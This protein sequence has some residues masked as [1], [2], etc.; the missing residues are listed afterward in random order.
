M[1]SAFVFSKK[2]FYDPACGR[3][4]NTVSGLFWCKISSFISYS[5]A[6]QE[7]DENLI[8]IACPRTHNPEVKYHQQKTFYLN[9]ILDVTDSKSKK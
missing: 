4:L 1:N 9:I 7:I 3:L 2:I 5:I 6:H 8:V